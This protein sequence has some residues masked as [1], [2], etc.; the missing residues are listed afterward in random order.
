MKKTYV[1][2][3][4]AK[5]TPKIGDKIKFPTFCS[6]IFK[7]FQSTTDLNTRIYNFERKDSRVTRWRH[8]GFISR[9][10]EMFSDSR[11]SKRC[12]RKYNLKIDEEKAK[13]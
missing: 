12:L 9:V 5:K 7:M 4:S 13:L 11:K 1:S 6:I 10:C 8:F 2:L 3:I